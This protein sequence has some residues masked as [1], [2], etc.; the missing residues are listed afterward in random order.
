VKI[1]TWAEDPGA[2]MAALRPI[3]RAVPDLS[4][5][6]LALRITSSAPPPGLYQR[7]TPEFRYWVAAEAL[8]RSS[9]FWGALLPSNASWH[10]TVGNRLD[11]HL[12]AG[13]DLNAFYD[14]QSL[15]FFHDTVRGMR[16]F[17]GESPDIGCHEL[18]HAVLDAIRP[19]LWNAASI[20]VAAFHEA[21]GDISA[22]LGALQLRVVRR[23]VL[24]ATGGDLRNS[25]RLS[26][27]AEQLGWA[28][29]QTAP[30]AVDPDCLRNAVNE[31]F[32]EDPATLPPSA[33]ASQLS[34]EEHSFSRVFTGAYFFAMAGMLDAQG[35][36]SESSLLQVSQDAGRLI[37]N[38]VRHTP[39]VAAYF[40][41][42]AAHVITADEQTF[43]GRYGDALRTAFLRFGLLSPAGVAEVLSRP[44]A[45]GGPRDERP[46][47]TTGDDGGSAVAAVGDDDDELQPIALTGSDFGFGE[48]VIV[49]A[50]AGRRRFPITGASLTTGSIRGRSAR[51]AAAAFL[52]DLVRRGQ[53]DPAET[54]GIVPRPPRRRV[55][56]ELRRAPEGL[57]LRRRLFQ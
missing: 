2:P 49:L 8:S 18:G 55:T 53:V 7:G 25:S 28:I 13:R 34:S 32:Y 16:V 45:D 21:F 52:E 41:Q 17:S 47:D 26:R 23:Q 35:S 44:V 27:L 40:S 5:L 12:D 1:K 51:D 37:V 9:S 24:R 38:A 31:F 48:D 57:I 15:Q 56:H 3:R 30:S 43:G 54:P 20:E 22:I 10:P 6:T 46:D 19:Q 14:R 36:T 50:P 29:R 42:I 4:E 33:P 39:V 11:V